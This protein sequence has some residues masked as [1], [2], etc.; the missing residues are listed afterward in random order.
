MRW[1]LILEELSLELIYFKGCKTT[2]TDAL[3]RLDKRD[4]PN[5]SNTNPNNK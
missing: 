1:Q 3:S 5:K 2:V 4:N